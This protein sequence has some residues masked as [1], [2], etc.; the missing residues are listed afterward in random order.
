MSDHRNYPLIGKKSG[1]KRH[2]HGNPNKCKYR[3]SVFNLEAAGVR[4]QHVHRPPPPPPRH[5]HGLAV[6]GFTGSEHQK[7][8]RTPDVRRPGLRFEV[9]R[10]G[11]GQKQR[12]EGMNYGLQCF[13]L[14]S[15]LPH[16]L[17]NLKDVAVHRLHPG[18]G[19]GAFL[20]FGAAHR[21]SSKPS[22]QS[23]SCDSSVG[24]SL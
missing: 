2:Y 14:I 15:L 20:T 10:R 8:D 22:C 13:L 9:N 17:C 6:V 16:L 23:G 4:G 11:G 19:G 7:H 5:V 18:N 12:W 21:L 24:S 1:S 3:R